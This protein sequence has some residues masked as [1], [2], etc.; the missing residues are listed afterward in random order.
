MILPSKRFTLIELLVV[1]AIIAILASLLL[2]ALGKARDRARSIACLSNCKQIGIAFFLYADD[3]NGELPYNPDSNGSVKWKNF[4]GDIWGSQGQTYN[5]ASLKPE[6]RP[7]NAYTGG[8][9]VFRCPA[10]NGSWHDAWGTSYFFSVFDSG[11]AEGVM[12]LHRN[13]APRGRKLA[14]PIW[15]NVMERKMLIVE[16]P[17]WSK[18]YYTSGGRHGNSTQVENTVFA[19]GHGATVENIHYGNGGTGYVWS[20]HWQGWPEGKAM[21]EDH[22]YY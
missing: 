9:R 11:G 3:S 15:E 16:P 2:P 6:N 5:I 19:D 14:D 1:I 8:G 13:D 7:L 20:W 17:W 21:T 18:Y 12:S 4:G 22:P 10:D